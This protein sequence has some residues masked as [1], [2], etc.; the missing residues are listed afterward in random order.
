[1]YKGNKGDQHAGLHY[2]Y[3]IEVSGNIN[4][5]ANIKSISDKIKNGNYNTYTYIHFFFFFFFYEWEHRTGT[6]CPFSSL[7]PSRNGRKAVKGI[8]NFIKYLKSAIKKSCHLVPKVET[9][10]LKE[11]RL[12]EA[13]NTEGGR[14][15]QR[16][17]VEGK[18]PS[19]NRLI[20]ALESSTQ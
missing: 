7:H 1:M 20:L 9:C 8:K 10:L 6:M 4:A 17:E 11:G 3:V 16:W 19:L 18:K 2:Q 5:N 12:K 14:E 13:G 15:F